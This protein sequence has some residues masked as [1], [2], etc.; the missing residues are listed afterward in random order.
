[1]DEEKAY[2]RAKEKVGNLK[3]FYSHLSAYIIVNVILALINLITSPQSLWFY[4]I[5]LF[6]GIAVLIHGW[7]TF[8]SNSLLGKDWEDQKIKEYMEKERKN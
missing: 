8:S 2:I 4:W 6:W 5:T 3:E 7:N 1:M